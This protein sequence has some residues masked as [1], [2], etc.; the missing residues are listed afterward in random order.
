MHNFPRLE[1]ALSNSSEFPKEHK[2]REFGQRTVIILSLPLQAQPADFE[3]GG[4]ILLSV[5]ILLY[6][7]VFDFF[8]FSAW[9]EI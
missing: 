4:S 5:Q 7:Y 9:F 6:L 3:L 2:K 1:K 8:F